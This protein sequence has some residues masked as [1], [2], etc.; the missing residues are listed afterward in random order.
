MWALLLGLG[1]AAH[2][3]CNPIGT[4][5]VCNDDFVESQAGFSSELR[6]IADQCDF[7]PGTDTP[8][9]TFQ[10]QNAN[11]G[12]RAHVDIFS[13]DPSLPLVHE[14]FVYQNEAECGQPSANSCISDGQ[15]SAL[16]DG[17]GS[18]R[19]DATN[20]LLHVVVM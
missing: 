8:D 16:W 11:V 20:D 9:V 12:Y 6:H 14:A 15:S 19:F 2:A 3:F 4:P 13:T 1:S 10:V 7:E 18:I 17:V 5:I